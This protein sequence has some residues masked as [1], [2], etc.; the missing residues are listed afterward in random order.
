MPA[1]RPD[2]IDDR[3]PLMLAVCSEDS[4]EVFEAL[5]LSPPLDQQD[6]RRWTALS[7][8]CWCGYHDIARQLLDA[9]AD[10]DVHESYAMADTP[11]SFAAQRGDFDLVRLLIARGADPDR[12]AGVA[13]MRA[14]SY[15]R[16]RGFHIFQ[17]FC[18]ITRTSQQRPNQAMQRTASKAATDVWRVCH[19]RFGCVAACHGLA[20]A[21]LVSR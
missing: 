17:S 8:A 5:L 14:E 20:V 3:T 15:A 10:P 12:Y 16:R 4:A 18:S 9:E 19:S 21:D 11:L 7:Y 13:A 6:S 1:V 2:P